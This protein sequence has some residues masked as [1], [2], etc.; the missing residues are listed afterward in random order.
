MNVRFLA[1]SNSDKNNNEIFILEWRIQQNVPIF[2]SNLR[3]SAL[4]CRQCDWTKWIQLSIYKK[5]CFSQDISMRRFSITESDNSRDCFFG[6]DKFSIC[7]K[8]FHC[9]T[10]NTGEHQK[11]VVE[12]F[13][14]RPL[15]TFSFQEMRFKN[16]RCPACC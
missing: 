10:R 11:T 6:R 5:I 2:S 12:T 13:V 8:I 7:S 15:V 3:P 4:Q 9:K 14:F 1:N 16:L